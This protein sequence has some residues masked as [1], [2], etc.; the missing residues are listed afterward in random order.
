MSGFNDYLYRLRKQEE[1]YQRRKKKVTRLC[2][3]YGVCEGQGVT[4]GYWY[5]GYNQ[6]KRQLMKLRYERCH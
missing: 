3:K 2:Q 5:S 4:W 1:L 6:T